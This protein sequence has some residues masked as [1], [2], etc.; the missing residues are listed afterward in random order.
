M[1]A[2]ASS[3][4]FGSRSDNPALSQKAFDQ[5]IERTNT[6]GEK[7]FSVVGTYL[8]TG[9]LF[10]LFL[11]AGVFGW[12]LIEVVD[13]QV[14]SANWLW[15][16]GGGIMAFGLA[17]LSRWAGKWI[18]IIAI[19]YALAQGVVIGL[20]S[21]VSEVA[22]PGI[23]FQAVLITLAL[24]V[25][26]WLL[27][28]TGIIKVTQG[29]RTFVM[30]GTVAV[31]LFFGINFIL[32]LF[33]IRFNLIDQF[34]WLGLLISAV[35]LLIG[36]L[37][38]PIDFDFIRQAAE[39]GAPKFLEWQGAFGLIITIIWIYMSVLRLLGQARGRS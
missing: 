26:T 32:S 1:T 34:S 19:L 17:I 13:G 2:R 5:Q 3:F 23:V 14:I 38:L 7:G 9:F 33:G 18:W 11:A 27:Y 29:Y 36:I 20:F 10:L 25:A 16:T 28:T 37:N 15:A 24:Y 8:K 21:H 22:Y 31:V 30:I 12:S 4:G 35:V 39:K 6:K